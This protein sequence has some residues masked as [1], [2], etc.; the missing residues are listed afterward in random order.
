MSVV[1]RNN[2]ISR[3]ATSLSTSATTLSV[4][5]GE[6]GKFPSPG[7][8]QWFPVTLVKATGVLEIIRCTSRTGDVLTV[9]R[10][11]EG[12]AAQA[13]SPG[14][15]VE[16]RL[17][18]A[19]FAEFQDMIVELQDM[20]EERLR[21]DDNLAAVED[22]SVARNNL[23][24]KTGATTNKQ[25]SSTD[26]T[27]G[28]LLINGAHGLGAA[29]TESGAANLNDSVVG[30]FV[31]TNGANS[32]A[33]AGNWPS[34]STKDG[35]DANTPVRWEVM[36][37]GSALYT[38]QVA[39]FMLSAPAAV[40]G[41]R[42]SRIKINGAWQSWVADF[43]DGL[44]GIGSK[45]IPLIVT[46]NLNSVTKYGRYAWSSDSLPINFPFSSSGYLDVVE[47][48]GD[49]IIQIATDRVTLQR[50]QR[51]SPTGSTW[52]SWKLVG[53]KAECSAWVN[54]NGTGTV[55]IR[56]S[57]N[58]S[59]ITDN[60]TGNY[61]VVFATSMTNANYASIATRSQPDSSGGTFSVG[62]VSKTVSG[63]QLLCQSSSGA[64]DDDSDV[65]VAVF[66][67]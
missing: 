32:N 7:V 45:P 49:D 51:T 58:V 60:G 24:L 30:S 5:V 56:D 14:D 50:Y 40:S 63:V 61:T 52:S 21:K 17:S 25:T 37:H 22:K 31:E 12:T 13:F 18:A 26:A 59:S 9:V 53:G 6:G 8:D 1:L 3:L 4:T 57:L 54:F 48:A 43:Y 62:T 36:T 29:V 35:A 39:T 67:G 34:L 47:I 66:G 20:I 27:A 44:Y 11:Q 19:A 64:N 15:R 41:R 46:D 42:Y 16:L 23:E 38:K 55:A 28:S 33:A 2:A 65:N 10:G